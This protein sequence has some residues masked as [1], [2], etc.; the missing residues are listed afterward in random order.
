MIDLKEPTDALQDQ[1]DFLEASGVSG[2][3]LGGVGE[4]ITHREPF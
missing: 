2:A 3:T 1:L 4:S